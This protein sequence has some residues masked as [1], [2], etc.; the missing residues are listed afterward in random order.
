MEWIKDF[1]TVFDRP[2]AT[3]PFRMCFPKTSL[4]IP[5]SDRQSTSVIQIAAGA[6]VGALY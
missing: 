4:V 6:R 3:I 1:S 2:Q 5:D